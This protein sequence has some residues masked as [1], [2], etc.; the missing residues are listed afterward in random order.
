M[1]RRYIATILTALGVV[2]YMALDDGSGGA[3][4]LAPEKIS[5]E[6]DYIISGLS[7]E[8]F[9]KKGFLDQQIDAKSATHY[10]HNNT[11]I[12]DSP[13]VIVREGE[14]PHWGVR[15]NIGELRGDEVLVLKGQVQ[16]VPMGKEKENFSLSTEELSIDLNNQIA[17]TDKLVTIESI[18]THLQAVGMTLNL[19]TEQ[20]KFKSKVR[21]QHDPKAN[22]N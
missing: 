12:L 1:R 19:A 5:T 20:A 7:A 13:S 18:S 15:A 4:L 2:G 21:G 6:P 16:I 8:H 14:Q 9:G 17:N 22:L 11:T 3:N 10:P